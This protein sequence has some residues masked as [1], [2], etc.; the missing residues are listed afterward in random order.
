MLSQTNYT[1]NSR[2]SSLSK[3][4]RSLAS[5]K[6]SNINFAIWQRQL[7]SFLDNWAEQV[8]WSKADTLEADINISTLDQ[9]EEDLYEELSK[10]RKGLPD[11]T[12][13]L[14]QDISL[15][16]KL[17]IETT[18]I[19]EAFIK[20]EPVAT[21]MCRLFHVDNNHLRML[22]TYIGQGTL[23]LP[24]DNANRNFLGRGDNQKVILNPEEIFQA[25]K[26]DVLIL[27][28]ERYNNNTVG[29][30]IHRSP[31]LK[32]GERRLLLK[33]DAR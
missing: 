14:A 25:K 21:D 12:R 2:G 23:W 15:N 10:W 6:N 1:Q 5:I 29:G 17:F 28:G 11:M 31:P 24:N 13:W 18:G 32:D 20:I 4:Q 16:I 22:C 30:A 33:V 27:K 7:E 26:L 3:N 19:Q 8:D 9:F